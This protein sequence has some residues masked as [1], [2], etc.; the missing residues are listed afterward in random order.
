M[1]FGKDAALRL[2]IVDDS[3]EAAEGVVSGLRNSGIA[4]RPSRPENA[5][6]L[7]R[8]ISQQS[9]DIALVARNA[10]SP[11]AAAAVF[12]QIASSGK[13]L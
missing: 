4:V 12:Q 7:A 11:V 13:D 8:L 6:D 3:V 9:P 10:A 1:Q 2:L 5:E